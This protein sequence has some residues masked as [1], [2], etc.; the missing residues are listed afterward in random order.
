METNVNYTIVGVFVISLVAAIVMAVLWMSAGFKFESYTTYALFMQDS[1]SGLNID[2]PVEYNGVNVGAVKSV[3]LNNLNPHL[4][5]VLLN[6]KSNTPITEGTIAT[7]ATRGLTGIAFIALKDKSDN[8][9]PLKAHKG[10]K[11]PII[12]T[13][14][15]LLTRLDTALSKLSDNIQIVTKSIQEL[16]N[17]RNLNAIQATLAN[18]QKI[19][20]YLA[21]NGRKFDEIFSNTNLASQ[22]LSPVL[23]NLDNVTRTMNAVATDIKQNPSVLIRGTAPLPLGPGETE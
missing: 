19:T 7:L 22:Q 4:V 5:N 12:Q 9:I 18:L 10:E 6:I 3:S 21:G 17:Q 14:P 8:R 20:G 11:Y 1:V 15:S 16:L 13:A 2:S 23:T